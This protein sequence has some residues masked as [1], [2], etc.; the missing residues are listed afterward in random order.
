MRTKKLLLIYYSV[1]ILSLCATAAPTEK[2]ISSEKKSKELSLKL[3][4][5]QVCSDMLHG[6][7]DYFSE[8]RD[9]WYADSVTPSVTVPAESSLSEQST[10]TESPPTS[11][12]TST[13]TS[14]SSES[15]SSSSSSSQNS[16]SDT[17]SSTSSSDSTDSSA[18]AGSGSSGT[19]ASTPAPAPT[20]DYT[21]P[22]VPDVSDDCPT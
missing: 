20:V 19:D 22:E 14:T 5:V 3:I 6:T 16:S 2:K 1:L 12:P 13:S 18:S 4:N 17:S 15:S 7:D 21:E 11:E 10:Q 8:D 9:A